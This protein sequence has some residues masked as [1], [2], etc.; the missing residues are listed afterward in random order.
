MTWFQIQQSKPLNAT[1]WVMGEKTEPLSQSTGWPFDDWRDNWKVRVYRFWN[2]FTFYPVINL[3]T[4]HA[5]EI[6]NLF[7]RRSIL[8]PSLTDIYSG[9]TP[10]TSR[11]YNTVSM[12]S[13]YDPTR[14]R[15]DSGVL[16]EWGRLLGGGPGLGTSC[17]NSNLQVVS[18][19]RWVIYL[20]KFYGL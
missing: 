17:W 13:P 10:S 12:S 15:T 14:L 19:S 5:L 8:R 2:I 18:S 20:C 3:T 11:G 9:L 4:N 1:G 16:F 7:G 6:V